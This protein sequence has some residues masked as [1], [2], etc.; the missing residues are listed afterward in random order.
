M[1]REIM[2]ASA[3]VSVVTIFRDAERFIREAIESVIEQT[4]LGWELLLV[5]DGS[6][7]GS[8]AIA[9][10]YARSGRGS[11]FYLRHPGGKNRG[12]SAS[13]NLGMGAAAGEFIS[14]LDADDVYLPEKLERQV[15]LL[16]AHTNAAM[17]YG[18]T[19]Q[20]HTWRSGGD[21]ATLDS[22]RKIGVAPDTLVQPPG[23]VRGFL[24]SDGWPPATCG[25]LVRRSAIERV[26]GFEERFRSLF[27]DQ[28][29]FYKLCL[30]FPVYVHGGTHD[31][32][33]QHSD[34][35]CERARAR[36]EWA[37][38]PPNP[39][40]REF[41]FWLNSYLRENGIHDPGVWMALRARLLPYRHPTL[42][43]VIGLPVRA[44]AAV[45]FVRR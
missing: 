30:H 33:R 6:S 7:D 17:V 37:P 3:R 44:R 34:S 24:K 39:A 16:D 27:E 38:R 18:A 22:T 25:V 8:A 42:Y 11:I 9:Q 14:F 35:A 43:R 41:V 31:L 5:D 40:H 36:G 20:W 13:R 15:A 10:G 1:D 21:E 29:F 28:A 4:Y 2:T 45:R 32:Y 19:L 26:G 23:L 12:M